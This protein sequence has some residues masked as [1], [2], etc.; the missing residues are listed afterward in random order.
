MTRFCGLNG[1]W[2]E[3][4]KDV[5]TIGLTA[6]ALDNMGSIDRLQLPQVGAVLRQGDVVVIF[7]SCKA[8]YDFESPC[9]GTVIAVNSKLLDDPC[10][11][12]ESTWL[13]RL[14]Q[15]PQQELMS[16]SHN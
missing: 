11:L 14:H 15:V 1:E 6:S 3:V 13:F 4:H 5:V 7:E 8:A 9:S 10:Q 2:I 12:Q 16:F